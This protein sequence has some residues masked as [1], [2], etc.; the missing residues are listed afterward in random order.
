MNSYL[1]VRNNFQ[2]NHHLGQVLESN[3]IDLVGAQQ[4]SSQGRKYSIL[5]NRVVNVCDMVVGGHFDI[6]GQTFL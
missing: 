5:I 2:L 3:G 4:S 6:L 1:S